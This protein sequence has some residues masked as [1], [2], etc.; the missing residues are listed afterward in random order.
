ME[1]LIFGHAVVALDDEPATLGLRFS[2]A[3]GRK[4][5]HYRGQMVD[6]VILASGLEPVPD[7]YRTG[8]IVPFQLTFTDS[9]EH[10][11]G[12]GAELYVD[13]AA[14]HKIAAVRPR[15][16]GLFGPG[17]N[18]QPSEIAVNEYSTAGDARQSFESLGERS[19]PDT[20]VPPT[21]TFS[22]GRAAAGACGR[23][24]YACFERTGWTGPVRL[25]YFVSSLKLLF[26]PRLSGCEITALR[27]R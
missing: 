5:F 1:D 17:K 6:G 10:E 12:V 3:Q 21:A 4:C 25:T 2:I 27:R 15:S 22:C 14:K 20:T 26:D 19:G 11:I 9:L 16:N 23:W 8:A 24:P 18:Q 7:E 13:R